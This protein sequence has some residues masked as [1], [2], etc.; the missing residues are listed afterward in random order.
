M[1]P[2][3]AMLAVQSKCSFAPPCEGALRRENGRIARSKPAVLTFG[4]AAFSSTCTQARLCLNY[5]SVL[6]RDVE[7]LSEW[8][9]SISA[10]GL[11]A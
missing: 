11:S 8:G 5:C 1:P 9:G 4:F 2:R 7:T 6:R 10:T 3:A